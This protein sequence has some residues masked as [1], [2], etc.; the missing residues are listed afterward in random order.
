[1][2]KSYLVILPFL[3]SNLVRSLPLISLPSTNETLSL[4]A[5]ADFS[6]VVA[7]GFRAA[8]RA[9]PTA[10]F[11]SVNAKNIYSIPVQTTL[12]LTNILIDF[13]VGAKP[14]VIHNDADQWERWFIPQ[15]E[16][17]HA[18]SSLSFKASDLDISANKA[19]KILRSARFKDP[20]LSLNIWLANVQKMRGWRLV[21]SFNLLTHLGNAYRAE[22]DAE[23]GKIYY[24]ETNAD[25][26]VIDTDN[27]LASRDT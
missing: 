9:H 26:L 3:L 10:V 5:S 25:T 6:R 7:A 11:Y 4:N 8:S 1:M 16:A 12:Q 22:V 21:Y 14:W 13:K 2:L 24:Q 15:Q 23:T 27:S 19:L 20:I 17:F 18:A